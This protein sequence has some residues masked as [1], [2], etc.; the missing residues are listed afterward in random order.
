[1]KKDKLPYKRKPCSNC[2]FRKDSQRG[3]LGAS[4]MTE[5]IKQDSFVCHKTVDYSKEENEDDPNR[6]QCAGHM[7]LLENNNMFVRLARA[8]RQKLNLSG[9]ELVFNNVKECIN[10]HKN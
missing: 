10:H 3:W 8:L 6:L 2:P 1:M 4:R 5:I 9:R 7:L